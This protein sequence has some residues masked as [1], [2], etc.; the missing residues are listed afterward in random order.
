MDKH[1]GSE[2]DFGDNGRAGS[3]SGEDDAIAVLEASRGRVVE[4][5]G[6]FMTGFARIFDGWDEF[7]TALLNHSKRTW[8][9]MS[10]RTSYSAKRRN[11]KLAERGVPDNDPQL[12]LASFPYYSVTLLC[13]HGIQ[14]PKKGMGKRQRRIIRFLVCEAKVKALARRD[15]E[16]VWKVNVSWEGAWKVNVSWEGAHNYLRSKELYG[17][18]SEN[19]RITD[20]EMLLRVSSMKKAGSSAKGILQYL[21]EET[22][23]SVEPRDVH[24]LIAL[25]QRQRRGGKTDEIRTL[26]FLLDAADP[27]LLT[28]AVQM[29]PHA[30][31]LVRDQYKFATGA[32]AQYE[33]EIDE[34]QAK[35][36]NQD[37][38][39]H[40]LHVVNMKVRIQYIPVQLCVHAHVAVAV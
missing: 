28:L 4:D 23:K 15:G 22:G 21:R 1:S 32:D 33:V 27:E 7:F 36:R 3:D 5:E 19:R 18:Y 29:N 6:T 17:Y 10:K 35:L 14:H 25:Q 11:K 16:G 34:P 40:D 31:R 39:E 38:G 8:Q 20:P 9:L 37:H 26:E 24:N 30:Y 13:T 2:C 12:L